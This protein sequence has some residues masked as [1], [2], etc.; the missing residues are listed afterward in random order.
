M[1]CLMP[2]C[3]KSARARGLCVNHHARLMRL[4]EPRTF[5]CRMCKES[6]TTRSI[7]KVYCST[8]CKVAFAKIRTSRNTCTVKDCQ[9]PVAAREMCILHYNRWWRYGDVNRGRAKK[10]FSQSISSNGYIN[11]RILQPDGSV[12]RQDEHRFVMES[13]LGRRLKS[14]EQ[15]HHKNGVRT[16]NRPE[17]LELWTKPQPSGQRV[18]DLVAWVIENYRTELEVA[19]K[20]TESQ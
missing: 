13:I 6:I 7:V 1:E 14:F 19:L 20:E 5:P 3:S 15:T 2:D 18:Q 12:I 10:P 9:R 17:N 11:Q 16:D 8:K 4:T